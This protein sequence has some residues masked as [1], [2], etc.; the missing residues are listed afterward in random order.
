MLALVMFVP[1]ASDGAVGS[2]DNLLWELAVVAVDCL[3]IVLA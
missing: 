2:E 1:H 3:C